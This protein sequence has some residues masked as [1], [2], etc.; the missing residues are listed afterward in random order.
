MNPLDTSNA[1]FPALL[2]LAESKFKAWRLKE[3]LPERDRRLGELKKQNLTCGGRA[4]HAL[5]IH[6]EFLER[7]VR[8]RIGFY[9]AAAHESRNLEMLSKSR[10]EE[11]GD[12]IMTSVGADTGALKG[13]IERDSRAAGDGTA[14]PNAQRYAHLEA[15]ILDIVNAELRVLEA[16]GNLPRWAEVVTQKPTQTTGE[17]TNSAASAQLVGGLAIQGRAAGGID[18]AEF[19]RR[20]EQDFHR[21]GNAENEHLVVRWDASSGD[22]WTFEG[23][24]YSARAFKVLA[25]QAGS[26]LTGEEGPEAWEVWLDA[27]R[28]RKYDSRIPQTSE[29]RLKQQV[30]RTRGLLAG[31][32]RGRGALAAALAKRR[33]EAEGKAMRLFEASNGSITTPFKNSALLCLELAA[34]AL[35]KPE[36]P[37]EAGADQYDWAALILD[38]ILGGEPTSD[39]IELQGDG[40][41]SETPY[42]PKRGP[43]PDY[44]TATRVAEIVDRIAGGEPWRQRLDDIC[45]ELDEKKVRCPK[46]WKAKG[47]RNW[48]T[49]GERHLVVEAIRDRLKLA[50]EK[51]PETI[52]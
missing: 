4:I 33:D 47:Y 21:Y 23:T 30:R 2:K 25:N 37:D 36:G 42:R 26:A 19:W 3:L 24:P 22:I 43:V 20:C 27:L 41:P 17:N 9:A 49:C 40:N 31:V 29:E 32:G 5:R 11:H 12:R 51:P 44:G 8:E 34:E 50:K 39:A 1:G 52:P 16:E 46:T 14:L 45:D 28:L 10:L 35:N 15:E 18:Q 48:S 6:R 13:H 7:E 38:P